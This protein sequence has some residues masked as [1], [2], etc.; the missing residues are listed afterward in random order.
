[1]HKIALVSL[2]AA[3]ALMAAVSFA[4]TQ[5]KGLKVSAAPSVLPKFA[6]AWKGET[7]C[8]KLGSWWLTMTVSRQPDGSHVTKVATEAVGQFTRLTLKGDA[9]TLRYSSFLKDT[10]YIGRFV[11]PDRIEGTVKIQEDCTWYLTR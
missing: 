7:I 8:P 5:P 6:G 3:A 4:A 9:V 2:V 1:M 10:T 11:S